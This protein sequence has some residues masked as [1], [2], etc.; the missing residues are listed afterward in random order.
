MAKQLVRSVYYYRTFA[1]EGSIAFDK[2][3]EKVYLLSEATREYEHQEVTVNV[4]IFSKQTIHGKEVI[5]GIVR[6]LRYIA[7]SVGERGTNSSHPILLK[8]D[9]GVNE[10]THFVYTPHN[11]VLA[12]EYNHHG[13]KVE[14]LFKLVNQLYRENFDA[15]SKNNSYM[16]IAGGDA[17]RRLENA[18][19]VRQIQFEYVDEPSPT[20][21]SLPL[22]AAGR[23]ALAIGAHSFEM[24]LKP[25]RGSKDFIMTPKA[26]LRKFLPALAAGG[27]KKMK[28]K[29]IENETGGVEEIDLV[30]DKLVKDFSAVI[31]SDG[32]KEINSRLLLESMMN[33]IADRELAP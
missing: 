9:E 11:H 31:L 6:L 7:P 15:G 23:E 8:D 1:P 21:E 25:E 14:L 13:P 33:D 19:G 18:V 20:K 17:I 12:V 2:K 3:L 28:V 5:A 27:Y 30:K 22:L 4:S 32:T 29:I 10:K 26:F 24:T 16:Y